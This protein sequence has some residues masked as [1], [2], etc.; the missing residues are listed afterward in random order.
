MVRCG[1]APCGC[2]GRCGG[3]DGF[4]WRGVMWCA[5]GMMWQDWFPADITDLVS[6]RKKHPVFARSPGPCY[7][8]AVLGKECEWRVAV[9][10]HWSELTAE[11]RLAFGLLVGGD[12]KDEQ[13]VQ[14]ARDVHQVRG[15]SS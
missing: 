9:A 5:I 15:N 2:I 7:C 12:A 6:F 14:A 3:G 4:G 13:V 8:F 11:R 1:P 10:R